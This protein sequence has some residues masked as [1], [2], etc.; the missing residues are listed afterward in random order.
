[1]YSSTAETGGRVGKQV[2]NPANEKI[3][4]IHNGSVATRKFLSLIHTCGER[5][6][7]DWA[8]DISDNK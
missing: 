7:N 4:E 1:M 5:M 3:L 2:R 8:K 6:E